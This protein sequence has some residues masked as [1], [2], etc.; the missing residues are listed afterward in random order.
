MKI[1]CTKTRQEGTTHELTR[2]AVY[3]VIGI[4]SDWYRVLNDGGVPALYPPEL[5]QV[6]DEERPGHWV[7]RRR[8]GTEYAYAPELAKPGFFEDFFEGEPAAVRTFNRY[9]N[10]HLRLTDAA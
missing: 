2:G 7:R 8:D 3:E 1:K 4:E 6:V 10:E 9:I 5:F